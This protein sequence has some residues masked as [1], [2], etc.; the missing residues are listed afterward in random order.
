MTIYWNPNGSP[1][2]NPTVQV[3]YYQVYDEQTKLG[4][5]NE[6]AEYGMPDELG[7]VAPN[8]VRL[9]VEQETSKT[10]YEADRRTEYVRGTPP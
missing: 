1:N 9:F 10:A 5:P 7:E 4:E 2:P 3:D 8:V 6:P